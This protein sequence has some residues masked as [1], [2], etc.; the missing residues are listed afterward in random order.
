MG[1]VCA[2]CGRTYVQ[3]AMTH[4]LNVHSN[5]HNLQPHYTEGTTNATT[6]LT[7]FAYS[8]LHTIHLICFCRRLLLYLHLMRS[9]LWNEHFPVSDSPFT[10]YF[11]FSTIFFFQFLNWLWSTLWVFVHRRQHGTSTHCA[12]CQ[13]RK[14]HNKMT[15]SK[16]ENS[17][18]FRVE[19]TYTSERTNENKYER[20]VERG[21]REIRKKPRTVIRRTSTSHS[22]QYVHNKWAHEKFLYDDIRVAPR[23]IR[24]PLII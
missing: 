15:K 8:Q 21:T 1:T 9:P 10:P 2:E 5:H 6:S 19:A 20:I 17:R 13:K 24:G 16:K 7:S 14:Y 12:H 22:Q 4:G 3:W 11:S 23:C 18:D